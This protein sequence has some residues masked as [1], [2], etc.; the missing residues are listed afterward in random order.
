MVLL[1]ILAIIVISVVMLRG[2]D[3]AAGRSQR[4]VREIA[5]NTRPGD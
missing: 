4:H 3:R 5:R 1:G 2:F